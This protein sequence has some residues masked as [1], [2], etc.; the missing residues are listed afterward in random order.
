MSRRAM[1][2]LFDR[3]IARTG[4]KYLSFLGVSEPTAT[5]E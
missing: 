5:L 2:V 1:S 3:F 4:S